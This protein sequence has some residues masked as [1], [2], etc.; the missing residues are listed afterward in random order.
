MIFFSFHSNRE[1]F[2]D[3]CSGK[4]KN[5]G[6]LVMRDVAIAKSEFV[7]GEKAVTKIQDFQNDPVLFD[8]CELPEVGR[9]IIGTRTLQK[10]HIDV[11]MNY[12]KILGHIDNVVSLHLKSCFCAKE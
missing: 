8:Y 10:G 7:Q 5:R 2:A 4:V 11:N 6:M 9:H 12:Q 3:I 1:R